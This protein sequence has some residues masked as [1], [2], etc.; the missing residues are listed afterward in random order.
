MTSRTA[1]TTGAIAEAIDAELVGPPDIK[2]DRIAAVD[3]AGPG[4]ITFLRSRR[5]SNLW[6]RSSASAAIVGPEADAR[7]ADDGRA[8]LFVTDADVALTKLLRLLAPPRPNLAPGIHSSAVVDA[9]AT[10]GQGAHVGPHCV[11]G[12]DA[13]IGDGAVL[14]ANVH[15]GR[16]AEIGAITT[17]HP[18]VV[19]LDRCIVGSACILYPNVVIGADGFG[20]HPSPDGRGLTKVPHIGIVRIGDGVEIGANSA[21]DRAKF[22]ETIIGDGTKIDNLV[23]VGHNVNIGRCV[24][25]CGCSGIAGSAT[26]GDGA[27]LGAATGVTD[28]RTVGPG[29]R[30]GARSAVMND[31]P[32]G[33]T[34]VG[35]PAV[36]SRNWAR[37]MVALKNLSA[38]LRIVRR[39]AKAETALE[40]APSDDE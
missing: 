37:A 19:I 23:Q 36:P 38:H 30:T 2:I 34:W 29:A 5:F 16:E 27:M 10:I 33:E 18:G 15:I 28:G 35:Y 32:A 4:A 22:G 25:I 6:A 17:L 14:I 8:L 12:A 13:V 11:I 20:Y 40:E 26:I 39:L 24:I 9:S 1:R 31:I 3:A 7:S 21:V